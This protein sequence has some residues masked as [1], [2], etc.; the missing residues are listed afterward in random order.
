[1]NIYS[2]SIDYTILSFNVVCNVFNFLFNINNCSVA[3]TYLTF[4]G[5]NSFRIRINFAIQVTNSCYICIDTSGVSIY[6]SRNICNVCCVTCYLF[7]YTSNSCCIISY[8]SANC[9]NICCI[10]INFT[11]N[12]SYIILNSCNRFAIVFNSF[13]ISIN[14]Y[15]YIVDLTINLRIVFYN[16]RIDIF[17]N[18]VNNSC[19][20]VINCS[21]NILINY[22]IVIIN[23]SFNV[24]VDY[25]VVIRN[26]GIDIV[27]N[28]S[29]VCFNLSIDC[30]F[31]ICDSCTNFTIQFLDSIFISS[32][33]CRVIYNIILQVIQTLIMAIYA[34]FKAR[35]I[36][37]HTINLNIYFTNLSINCVV[38]LFIIFIDFYINILINLVKNC[39]IVCIN[40]SI[41]RLI[42]NYIIFINFVSNSIFDICNLST[43][44]AFQIIDRFC[45][46]IDISAVSCNVCSIN[47]YTIFYNTNACRVICNIIL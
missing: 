26:C 23:S 2:I 13:C 30:I 17:I 37:F 34:C 16:L 12:I 20:V 45:I 43:N 41:D 18:L 47:F 40:L 14:F 1:M 7:R 22:G 44:M 42:N 15:I 27:S 9:F 29:V 10:H 21:F 39:G 36:A 19:V 11:I 4:Q 46:S 31:Y 28:H 6:L 8:I 33:T 38:D 25:C 3:F 35:Y 32:N 24:L 5:F